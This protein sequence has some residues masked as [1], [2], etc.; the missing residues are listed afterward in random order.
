MKLKTVIF[1]A[2]LLVIVVAAYTFRV[3]TRGVDIGDRVVT[4][5]IKPGDTMSG[6]ARQL[7]SEG[8]VESRTMLTYPA[9]LMKIDRKLTPGRYDFTGENSCRSVLERLMAADF[10][11]MKVTIP[12]GTTIWKAAAIV[13]EKLELDSAVFASLDKDSAFLAQHNLPGL[14]GYLFPETYFIPWGVD[15]VYVAGEMIRM[16]H[17]QTDSIWPEDIIDG[18]SRY[19]IVKLASIVEAETGI[20]DERRLVASVYVN[21]MRKKMKLD[22]DPTV[23]YGLGGLDRPLWTKDLRKDTPY[24]TYMHRGL[25]PTPINSPGLASLRAALDP[26]QSEYYYFVAD[27]TGGHVF[28]RTNAE[29][30]RA[31]ERIKAAL[32]DKSD[33]SR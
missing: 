26:E 16:F 2:A 8:V 9:R 33:S 4:V 13:A 18:L 17:Q 31:K 27:E 7:V 21:R 1:V 23:I 3:Y 10:L 15:E 30:N 29:H 6:I 28:S 24:N 14:E 22:A 19:E 20:K 5:I 12:E 32:K 11:R 25:P